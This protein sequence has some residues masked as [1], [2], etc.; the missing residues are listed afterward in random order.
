MSTSP[1]ARL[2]RWVW[3]VALAICAIILGVVAVIITNKIT[4]TIHDSNP[5]TSD[6]RT[7][8]E[9]QFKTEV[10]DRDSLVVDRFMIENMKITQT[11]VN[12]YVPE[13][14]WSRKAEYQVSGWVDVQVDVSKIEVTVDEKGVAHIIMPQPTLSEPPSL[15]PASSAKLSQDCGL[16]NFACASDTVAAFQTAQ[17]KFRDTAKANPELMP[18]ARAQAEKILRGLLL[19]AGAQDVKFEWRHQP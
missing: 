2:P 3:P 19:S 9:Q 15:D 14:V 17:G 18:R 7:K 16:I 8:I 6:R 11:D 5:F 10:Q 12:K 1:S 4:Q 13:F